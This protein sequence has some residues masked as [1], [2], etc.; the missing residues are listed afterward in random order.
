[1]KPILQW[2]LFISLSWTLLGCNDDLRAQF[3]EEYRPPPMKPIV[4]TKPVTPQ[5]TVKF[6]YSPVKKRDPFRSHFVSNR[7]NTPAPQS[8]A[9]SS[10]PTPAP[11]LIPKRVLTP[12]ERYELDALRVVATITGVAN[13]VAMIEVPDGNRGFIARRGTLIGRNSGRIT[14][15]YPDSIVVSEIYRDVTGKRIVNRVRINIQRKKQKIE[16]SLEI[17]GR[18]II[19]GSDGQ[20]DTTDTTATDARSRTKRLFRQSGAGVE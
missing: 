17:G 9:S 1:M 11:V 7:E 20:T 6:V 15:I 4:R 19:L 13:P 16:G 5:T 8:S 18:K 12:L 3:D 2:T 10:T 14:R